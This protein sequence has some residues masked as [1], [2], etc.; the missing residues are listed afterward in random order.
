MPN[1]SLEKSVDSQSKRSPLEL[2][3]RAVLVGCRRNGSERNHSEAQL[4]RNRRY[5][6]RSE[7]LEHIVFLR[8]F[9]ESR[10]V[11]Q[12]AYRQG[13][14]DIGWCPSGQR[15][16][17][18]CVSRPQRMLRRSMRGREREPAMLWLRFFLRIASIL[19]SAAASRRKPPWSMTGIVQMRAIGFDSAQKIF[20]E[21]QIRPTTPKMN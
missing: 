16:C 2:T 1:C 17:Q 19:V 21:R 15:S 20:M 13:E 11:F 6:C 12:R 10:L 18:R 14:V 8:L 3:R 5:P 9:V 4:Q 7:E